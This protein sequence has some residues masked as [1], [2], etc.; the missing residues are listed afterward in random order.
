MIL[1][2]LVFA[3]TAEIKNGNQ[4]YQSATTQTSTPKSFHVHTTCESHILPSSTI[5]QCMAWVHVAS[6]PAREGAPSRAGYEARVH[7]DPP[8]FTGIL[9]QLQ[10]I[11]IARG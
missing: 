7:V 8:K 10:A 2:W 3:Q 1:S 9:L 6:Y 4:V 5:C 11:I